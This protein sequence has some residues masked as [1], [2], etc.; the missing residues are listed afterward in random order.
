MLWTILFKGSDDK[1]ISP[2]FKTHLAQ[3]E[4]PKDTSFMLLYFFIDSIR[5]IFCTD[6]R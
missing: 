3:R 5:I 6:T 1:L 4:E 2:F